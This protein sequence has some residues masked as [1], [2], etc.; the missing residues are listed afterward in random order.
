MS[1]C[2]PELRDF[3]VLSEITVQRKTKL[4]LGTILGTIGAL[5]L[6]MI[7]V[8]IVVCVVVRKKKKQMS[9]KFSI[10]N[11]NGGTF[12][13]G[14]PMQS[15][16]PKSRADNESHIYAS[17]ED[18]MVYGHLLRDSAYPG[19]GGPEVDVYRTFTGPV[20]APAPPLPN[21]KEKVPEVTDPEVGVYRHFISPP[22]SA[23]PSQDMSGGQG[24][25]M[26][27][28]ELYSI[29]SNGLPSL[30]SE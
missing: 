5:L 8:L 11:P 18:T 2:L 21:I 19:S 6:L 7:V 15:R 25:K 29:R 10:Y 26:V 20:E 16:F 9:P 17:I 13:P 14:H 28:N 24:E 23:P 27:E 1:N 3:S 22:E 30:P 4:I 12:A